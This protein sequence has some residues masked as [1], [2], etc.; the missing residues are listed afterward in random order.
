[1]SRCV[2]IGVGCGL[3]LT[4]HTPQSAR[5]M[6]SKEILVQFHV[7]AQ[8]TNDKRPLAGPTFRPFEIGNTG[9]VID[10]VQEETNKSRTDRKPPGVGRGRGRGRDDSSGRPAK[11]IGR[12]QEDGSGKG[13]GSGR[14]RGGSGGK[15]AGSKDR[16]LDC[17]R[18]VAMMQY[19]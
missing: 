5:L 15:G 2:G 18:G 9:T 3:T 13:G 6:K 17:H 16:I 14:G 10:K 12:G 1:M 4:L 19:G 7:K 8:P 11:S